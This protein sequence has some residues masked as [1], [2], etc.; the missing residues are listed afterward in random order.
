MTM[1]NVPD[2]HRSLRMTTDELRDGFLVRNLFKDDRVT[3]HVSDLDRV[4]LAGIVPVSGPIDLEA[5]AETGTGRLT[6]RREAGILNIGGEGVIHVS[7]ERHEM[8]PLDC[9]YVGRGVGDIRFESVSADS[10][11]RYYLV[12]YPSH[13]GY[14]TAKVSQVDVEP[15]SLGSPA[16]ANVRKLYK[17]IHPD[18]I[19]S[20]QLVMGITKLETGSVWNT[21]PPHTHQRRSEVYLYFGLN[22]PNLVVHLMGKPD[23]TRSLIVRNHEAVLSPPWSIH[24]GAGTSAYSFCWAMGGENQEFSDMQAAPLNSLL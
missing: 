18:G 17:Y 8:K 16:E 13:Q 19:G 14:P 5:P 12:S 4:I 21:M 2:L 1:H 10:P 3:Y 7:G 15:V 20:S 9:L 6:D 11:A 22:E 23:S 24:A